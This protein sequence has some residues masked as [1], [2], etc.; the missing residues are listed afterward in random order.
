M[1]VEDE[2][3][4][5]TAR[6]ELRRF[7][8][9]DE[10]LVVGLDA[11]PEVMRYLTGGRPT[12]PEEVRERVLPRLMR[13]Y[14]CLGGLPGFWAA[15]EGG[16]FLGWFELR[17]VREDSA[18]TLELGYRLRRAAWGAGYA[19]EGARALVERAFAVLGAERVT[20]EAMAVNT[21]SRRVM[22]KSGLGYVRTY[23]GEWPERIEGSEHGEVAYAL[24]RAEWERRPGEAR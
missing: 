13:P 3:F 6:L 7:T 9:R 14:A 11:D 15:R 19:T 20:A 21:G 17:P 1:T 16:V 12:P 23:F 4:L 22:E 18:D 24:T 5:R 2:P 8:V 10:P